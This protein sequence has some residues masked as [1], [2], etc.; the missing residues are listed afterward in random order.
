MGVPVTPVDP[1]V[2][3]WPTTGVPVMVALAIAGATV[4]AGALP[5]PLAGGAG[6]G[7]G[8]TTAGVLSSMTETL[9]LTMLVPLSRTIMRSSTLICLETV[10]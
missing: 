9:E 2:R 5:P 6:V 4:V 1:A 10:R 8:A 7:T 3:T